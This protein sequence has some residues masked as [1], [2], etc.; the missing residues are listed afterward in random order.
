[1]PLTS[2]FLAGWLS[3]QTVDVVQSCTHGRPTYREAN[4]LVFENCA[5]MVPEV[6]GADVA[7]IWVVE[8]HIHGKWKRRVIYGALA[9]V[10]AA[11]VYHN[12]MVFR[13]VERQR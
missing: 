5:L 11:V 12:A 6:V 4:P 1:M 3:L 10:E 7:T 13:Q 9:G 8:K 2:L